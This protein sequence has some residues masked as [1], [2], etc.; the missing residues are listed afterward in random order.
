MARKIIKTRF[1]A[2]VCHKNLQSKSSQEEQVVYTVSLNCCRECFFCKKGQK[3]KNDPNLPSG[4][5]EV[6][7]IFF[8][9]L[10]RIK[11]KILINCMMNNNALTREY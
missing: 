9:F 2:K 5:L 10:W 6:I 8:Y 1:I 3:C 11:S 4:S 7:F